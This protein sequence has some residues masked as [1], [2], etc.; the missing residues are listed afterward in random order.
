MRFDLRAPCP[1]CPF[2]TDILFHLHPGRVEAICHGIVVDHE[3]F[4]CHKTTHHDEDGEYVPS[5]TD[6]HCYG[7]MVFLLKQGAPNIAMRLAA[8]TGRLDLGTIDL[9]APV[10]ESTEQMV[11]LRSSFTR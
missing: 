9:D 5:K 8:M 3:Q 11:R 6:Q 4:I 1:A 2:R 7:A 10:V